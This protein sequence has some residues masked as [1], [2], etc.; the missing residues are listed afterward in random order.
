MTGMR[1]IICVRPLV[2]FETQ[3]ITSAK[4]NMNRHGVH[5]EKLE[6]QLKELMATNVKRIMPG[7]M[8]SH[9][10]DVQKMLYKMQKSKRVWLHVNPVGHKKLNI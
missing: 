3:S 1:N 8:P 9:I 2:T 7:Q 6:M 4:S 10:C 5:C